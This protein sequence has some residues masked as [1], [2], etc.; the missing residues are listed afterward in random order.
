MSPEQAALFEEKLLKR[1]RANL[2]ISFI[3]E[4]ASD[5]LLA[6]KDLLDVKCYCGKPAGERESVV[7]SGSGML[8]EVPFCDEC[9]DKI[10]DAR[11][12]MDRLRA[13]RVV[14]SEVVAQA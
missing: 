11:Q 13:S 9:G 8:E 7:V 1:Q 6:K 12:V 10:K 14:S 5:W 3:R 2:D 4:I